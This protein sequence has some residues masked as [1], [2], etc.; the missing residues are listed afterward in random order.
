MSESTFSSE[1]RPADR[2]AA[3]R[4]EPAT[5]ADLGAIREAY[6]AG[7]AVQRTQ[8]S[9]VWPEFSDAAI[10]R[11]IDSGSLFRVMDAERLAGVF[12]LVL[13]DLAIWGEMERG[14][15]LYLHR[16]SRAPSHQGG[17]LVRVILAW[18]DE[19]C[20]ALGRAGLRMDTW[21]TN[22]PLIGYYEQLGFRLVGRR[23]MPAD[24]R[25]SPHYHGIELALLERPC[26][27]GEADAA[28]PSPPTG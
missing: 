20:R 8:G 2:T 16:I 4:V 11:E 3:L 15:H 5:V 7:R 28:R 14:E 19:R 25:L 10:A 18:A 22:A 1:P 12:S 24:P 9:S 27:D 26:R 13:A 17:G 23:L 21:A 6:T